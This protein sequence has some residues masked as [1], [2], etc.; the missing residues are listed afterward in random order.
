M[1]DVLILVFAI[2]LFT[3]LAF[4]RVGAAPVAAL[5]SLIT[6][7]LAGLPIL[8]T[9]LGPFMEAAAGYVK[10]YFFIFFLGACFSALYEE[11]KAA[12][13]IALFL[14]T[15]THGKH[16][17]VL[18]FTVTA[19]LTYGGISGFVVYFVMYPI[20]LQLFQ[21]NN[22]TRILLPGAITAGCWT[23]SMVAPGSPSVQNVIAMK[24]LGTP[25]TAALIPGIAGVIFEYVAIVIWFEYRTKRLQK[26]GRHFDD[27]DLPPL[28]ENELDFDDDPNEVRPGA[29]LSFVP[30]AIILILFNGFRLPVEA[31][32]FFGIISACFLFFKHIRAGIPGYIELFN[33]GGI[34]AGTSL[35]NTAIVV[36]FGGVAKQT[37]GFKIVT[38]GMLNLHISPLV[39]VAVAVA[40]CAGVCGSASGGMGIA[41]D[42]LKPTF[43][44]LGLNLEYVHRIAAIAAG[45]LDTLPHQGGQM[46]IY[47]ITHMNHK[48]AY[49]DICVTQ[50]IIPLLS[51]IVVI[52][53]CAMGL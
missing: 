23:V 10:S 46:T 34:N 36:G 47:A 8:D 42:A 39:Y 52:P 45:T 51:L 20:A 2:A 49:W 48:W 32:V 4:N 15:L 3:F 31:A 16:I 5:V 41:F 13:S 44:S 11:S 40:V 27:P 43:I 21:K 53:L 12:K 28:P 50:L 29:L 33:R 19:I 37:A 17:A 1:F 14:G 18:I 7:L 30:I 38:E 35:L 22:L 26:L 24:S 6:I 9:L 25:S